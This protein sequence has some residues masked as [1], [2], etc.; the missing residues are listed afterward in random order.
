MPV[1]GGNSCAWSK[2]AVAQ[3]VVVWQ[4]S[5][6][7]LVGMCRAGLAC[8]LCATIVL[9]PQFTARAYIE[10]IGCYRCTWLT[11]VPPMI[12]MMLLERDL[13]G[14]TDL[15][16]VEFIDSAGLAA[17]IS[18]MKRARSQ[19]GDL[20][21]VPPTHPG[22]IRIFELTCLADVFNYVDRGQESTQ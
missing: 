5:H 7:S 20:C 11:A 13:L 1:A 6:C 8:A 14:S 22:A 9:L 18:G 19:G 3:V 12:A 4:L 21:L 10:A 15:S 16:S 2:L 17:L